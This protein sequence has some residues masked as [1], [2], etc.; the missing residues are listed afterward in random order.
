LPK[1][2]AR[3]SIRVVEPDLSQLR[4]RSEI[5]VTLDAPIFSHTLTVHEGG[6]V[7][8]AQPPKPALKPPVAACL[9]WD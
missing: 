2:P 9:D 5:S 1:R 4:H 6:A 8:F 7:S 3:R